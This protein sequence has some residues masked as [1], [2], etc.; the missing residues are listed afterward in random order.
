MTP[1]RIIALL[2]FVL[3]AGVIWFGVELFEPFTGSGHGRVV[4]TVPHGD[5]ASAVGDLLAQRGVVASGFFFNLYAAIQGD[6]GD[7]HSGQYVLREGMS[8]SA[9]LAVLTQPPP[10]PPVVTV[11]IPEGDSRS[12]IAAVRAR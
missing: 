6:R 7:L 11:V 1:G 12:E 9:A 3:A 8:Y 5:G 10:P 2:V 4:V